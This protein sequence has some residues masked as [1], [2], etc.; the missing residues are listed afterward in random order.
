V[1]RRAASAYTAAGGYSSP[2]SGMNE[3]FAGL[4]GYLEQFEDGVLEAAEVIATVLQEYAKTHHLWQPRTGD[5][6]RSTRG[7]VAM[8]TRE[9]VLISLTAG[10]DYD[11]ML[12]LARN[13][14]WAWLYPAVMALREEIVRIMGQRV[15]AST[16]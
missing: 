16:R 5:T 12:E 13:G 10:M 1:A 9:Y 4:D 11:V 7:R 3:V 2:I 14:K 8:Q 6:T 15:E